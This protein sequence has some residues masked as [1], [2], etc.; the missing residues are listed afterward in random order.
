MVVHCAFCAAPYV[1]VAAGVPSARSSFGSGGRDPQT[2]S[3]RRFPAESVALPTL[4][5]PAAVAAIATAVAPV[6]PA[7]P[8]GRGELSLDSYI[9]LT[10]Q[11][12]CS[13]EPTNDDRN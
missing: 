10:D 2:K 4:L 5:T 1:T 8:T 11:C 9:F 13:V 6:A 3:T 12:D 7:S